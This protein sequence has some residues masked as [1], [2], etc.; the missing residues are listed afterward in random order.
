[1]RRATRRLVMKKA[2]KR[3]QKMKNYAPQPRSVPDIAQ[4]HMPQFSTLHFCSA[5]AAH[6]PG[7]IV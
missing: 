1:M 6:V 5:S 4:Q 2:E 7:S 3:I